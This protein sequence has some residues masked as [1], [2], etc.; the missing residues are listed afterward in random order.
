[1]SRIKQ[2]SGF[3]LKPTRLNYFP[4]YANVELTSYC[5]LDCTMCLRREIKRPVGNM[6][7]EEFQVVASKVNASHYALHGFGEPLYNKDIFK[8]IRHIKTLGAVSSV[9]SNLLLLKDNTG[10]LINSGLRILKCSLDAGTANTYKKIRDSNDYD[11]L[12][13]NLEKFSKAKRELNSKWPKLRLNVVLREENYRELGSIL[14][15]ATR[16]NADYVHFQNLLYYDAISGLKSPEGNAKHYDIAVI[17][18]MVADAFKKAG[19][20][21]MKTNIKSILKNFD[22][23]FVCKKSEQNSIKCY[24]PWIAIYISVEG[25]IKP[26]DVL[27]LFSDSALGNIFDEDYFKIIN[28]QKAISFRQELQKNKPGHELCSGC[29]IPSIFELIG[30]KLT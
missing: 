7:I 14:D 18:A 30:N 26:C 29:L 1:M 21:N 15:I 3:L 19:R 12:L 27:G 10:E 5:N 23:Y 6:T 28:S 11:L 25:D 24:K 20:L 16:I 22:T 17:K 9:T 8:I 13:G 2:I 4:Y